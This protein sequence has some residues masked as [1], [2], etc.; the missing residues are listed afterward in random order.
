MATYI[1]YIN[2]N[3]EALKGMKAL[4]RIYGPDHVKN[5]SILNLDTSINLLGDLIKRVEEDKREEPF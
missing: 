1:E 4:Y 2:S 5:R 3:I